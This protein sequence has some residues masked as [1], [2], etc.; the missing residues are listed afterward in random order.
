MRILATA[1]LALVPVVDSAIYRDGQRIPGPE[2]FERMLEACTTEGGIAWIG[3]YRPTPAE[4]ERVAQ[5]FE[6]HHLAVE[7]ALLGHQRS[8]L[9]RYGDMLFLVLRSARYL[10]AEEEVEFGEIEIFVGAKFVVTV[11]HAESPD[12]HRVRTRLEAEPDL[13]GRGADAILYALLD[14]IVDGYE[15]VVSGLEND[16][17]EIEDQL[18]SSQG[19]ERLTK[20]IYDLSEEVV[21][22]QRAVHPVDGMLQALLDGPEQD[23]IDDEEVRSLFRDVQDHVRSGIARADQ[24]RV[25]LGNALQVQTTL[26]TRAMT[27]TSIAQNEQMKKITSWAAILFAPSL[28][29]SIYGMNFSN[30]PEL[31]WPWGYPFALGLMLLIAV[32][33]YFVFKARHWL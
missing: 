17:D 32:I 9:E 11:R 25:L 26:V 18:F 30:M 5:E 31:A 14:E 27:Q 29:G 6:F 20:R 13:L 15:P 28:I 8:K 2:N 24:F 23:F 33:L 4:L 12:L 21:N 7:D 10:D 19:V 22:F 16:I 1:K 3:L